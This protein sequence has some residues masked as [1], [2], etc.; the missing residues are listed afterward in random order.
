[1]ISRAILTVVLS[2]LFTAPPWFSSDS[3]A[4]GSGS[5]HSS[6]SHSCGH[7]SSKDMGNTGPGYILWQY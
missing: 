2:F 1:M 3:F 7:Y 6:G 4:R 5:S